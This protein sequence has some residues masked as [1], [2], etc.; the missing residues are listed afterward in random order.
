MSLHGSGMGEAGETQLPV[1]PGLNTLGLGGAAEPAGAPKTPKS[2][3]VK[4]GPPWLK[5]IARFEVL[6][7]P[8]PVLVVAAAQVWL[9]EFTWMLLGGP[10]KIDTLAL[11]PIS[12]AC[13][14]VGF[15]TTIGTEVWLDNKPHLA[16]ARTSWVGD[17]LNTAEK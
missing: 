10:P 15:S 16:L 14:H 12:N 4:L 6:V 11:P 13:W 9:L 2:D 1:V 8:L 7:H 5:S 17:P 3:P